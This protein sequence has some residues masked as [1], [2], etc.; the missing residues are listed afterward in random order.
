MPKL[1][2]VAEKAVALFYN[3]ARRGLESLVLS[4]YP[5]SEW[6]LPMVP[7]SPSQARCIFSDGSG[8]VIPDDIKIFD[9]LRKWGSIAELAIM[10]TEFWDGGVS[11]PTTKWM[12]RVVFCFSHEAQRFEENCQSILGW[13]V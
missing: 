2:A 9:Q 12:C 1:I 13:Q 6:S 10:P 3:L 4:P 7:T 11:L 8:D 5:K